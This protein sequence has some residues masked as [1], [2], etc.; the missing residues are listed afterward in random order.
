MGPAF[1]GIGG[2]FQA[3]AATPGALMP[4]VFPPP[5]GLAPGAGVGER[6]QS[7]NQV[8]NPPDVGFFSRPGTVFTIVTAVMGVGLYVYREQTKKPVTKKPVTKRRPSVRVEQLPPPALPAAR[9]A[10]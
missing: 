7:L 4:E 5:E 9:G 8:W 1:S 3:I 10:E 6:I 2:L